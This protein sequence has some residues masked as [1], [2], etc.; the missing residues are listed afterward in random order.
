MVMPVQEYELAKR[1]VTMVAK[2]IAI[3]T[4]SILIWPLISGSYVP[5]AIVVHIRLL[6]TAFPDINLY[7]LC[8]ELD[9]CCWS[10][11]K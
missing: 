4:K 5:G 8:S 6:D 3:R 11:N 7:M 1:T 2:S 10:H 9:Q